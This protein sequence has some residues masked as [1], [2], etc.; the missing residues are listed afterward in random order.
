MPLLQAVIDTNLAQPMRVRALLGKHFASLKEIPIA[1]LGL[2]FKPDTDDIRET[3]AI[4]IIKKL[5]ADG[6]II[7]VY[8]PIAMQEAKKILGDS[9]VRYA[10]SLEQCI[11]RA[12]AIVLVTRWKEFERLPE[13]LAGRSPQPLVIDGRRMLDKNRVSRYEGIGL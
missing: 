7:S 2:A 9:A 1:V 12:E 3:P 4:P 8:D 5:I 6:A 10:P 11:E 13:I